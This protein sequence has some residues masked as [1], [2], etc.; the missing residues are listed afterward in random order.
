[1]E[2]LITVVHVLAA[3][4]IIFLVL[5]QHGKGADAGAS[6]GSGASQTVFGSGGSGNF[7]TKSTTIMAIV[8]FVT[9][10][11]LAVTAKQLSRSGLQSSPLIEQVVDQSS[12]AEKAANELSVNIDDMPITS[13][14]LPIIGED[15]PVAT[16]NSGEQGEEVRADDSVNEESF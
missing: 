16:D 7:L 15:M 9:S 13:L 8:F 4:A 6:F 1:M 10:L 5:I 12:A 2:T 11:S 14:D 3:I